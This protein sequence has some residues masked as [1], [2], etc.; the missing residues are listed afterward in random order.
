MSEE[1]K[2]LITDSVSFVNVQSHQHFIKH[3]NEQKITYDVFP[4]VW[5]SLATKLFEE[6]E[7]LHITYLY[8]IIN[9]ISEANYTNERVW[10]QFRDIVKA[11][12]Y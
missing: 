1:T 12:S 10:M 6:K 7:N 4:E 2:K 8:R 5:E 9:F 3:L 11:Q